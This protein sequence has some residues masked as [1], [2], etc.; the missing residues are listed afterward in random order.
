MST[1]STIARPPAPA[2][3][4][5]RPPG[6]PS[7][8]MPSN[9]A[10]T[11]GPRLSTLFSLVFALFGWGVG[12]APLSDNSFFWHLRTGGWILDHGI[13][14]HDPFSYTAPGTRWIAQSW[15]AEL[16]YGALDRA[17][18]PLAIRVLMGLVGIL[19]GVLAYRLALRITRDHVVAAGITI[20]ALGGIYTLW[21]ERP[22]LIGVV[23]LLAL[24]WAIEVPDSW[25]GRRPI[26]ALPVLFW[27]WANIHGTFA[28]GFAYLAL[29]LAGRWLDGA[30]PWKADE[31]KLA[32]AGL[33]AFVVIFANPYGPALVTF[34]LALL[35]RGDIL[36]HIVEWRSPD[37]RA[38]SGMALGLWLVVFAHAVARGRHRPSR[39][40]LVV[41]LPML[42]LALWA[43][44]NVA[45][46][47]LVGLPVVARAVARD[48]RRA[49]NPEPG[50]ARIAAVVISLVAV[51]I[52]VRAASQPSFALDSYP[53]AAMRWVDTHGL[54]GRRL[55]T[56][57][58][59][60]GYVILR[61]WPNQSVFIDDRY[62][63][64]PR[65]VISD[66]FAL[67]VANPQ[68]D[69]ILDRRRVEVVVWPRATALASLLDLSP[70]WTRLHR[71]K[72]DGI[73]VRA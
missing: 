8:P 5:E 4:L 20:A 69:R 31:R 32:I 48:T 10:G 38:V 44:R 25:V 21:S 72:G 45:I 3:A 57:D 9:G 40:D 7:S 39:R 34:P 17:F 14:H 11:R 62:D 70:Q 46:A 15:L 24:A 30:P 61:Y 67:A 73:W 68:W 49:D 37:F 13:P 12:S 27:L 65:R 43:L 35:A 60:A 59:D 71:D 54:L 19:I 50:I 53:V 18:G 64:Y 58:S 33:V 6:S 63:M 29:H 28:L 51:L 16:V 22:L 23:C 41:T 1:A 36:K 55:L 52:G 56:S 2:S 42:L 47:P 26:L 66:Y